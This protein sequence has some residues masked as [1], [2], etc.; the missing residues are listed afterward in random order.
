MKFS[1]AEQNFKTIM[2]YPDQK[3]EPTLLGMVT[4]ADYIIEI[5]PSRHPS[6]E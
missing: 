1:K 3:P 2:F 6:D 4:S 5:V